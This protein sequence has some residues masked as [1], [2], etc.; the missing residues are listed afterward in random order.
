MTRFLLILALLL[1]ATGDAQTAVI[2]PTQASFVASADHTLVVAGTPVV[3]A[4]QL[5]VMVSTPT[6]AL[7]FTFNLGKPTPGTGNR[8]AV[9]VPQLATLATGAYVATV[10][11]V[12]PGGAGKSIPSLPFGRIGAATA[13]TDVQVAP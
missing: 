2:N 13:P 4:Y 6:G 10:S 1:P 12:G 8:I 11:A 7:A 5:D 3:T 9:T